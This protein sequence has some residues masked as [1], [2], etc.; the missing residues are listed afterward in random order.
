VSNEE[1]SRALATAETQNRDLMK[2][3]KVLQTKIESLQNQ[4]RSDQAEVRNILQELG[5]IF[6][7]IEDA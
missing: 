1:L 5:E 2:H 3:S 7:E 6:S 4:V